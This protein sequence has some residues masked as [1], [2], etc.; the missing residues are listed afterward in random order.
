MRESAGLGPTRA[1]LLEVTLEGNCRGYISRA[2]P[3]HAPA[4]VMDDGPRSQ[5]SM[6][7]LVAVA[8][9]SCSHTTSVHCISRGLGRPAHP[10]SHTNH[11]HKISSL[12]S[13]H[14][15]SALTQIPNYSVGGRTVSGPL[16][17]WKDRISNSR[18]SLTSAIALTMADFA[19]ACRSCAKWLSELKAP[20][21]N[22]CSRETGLG[23]E[24]PSSHH[25]VC[26]A[27]SPDGVF[28][29]KSCYYCC[30][31]V[32]RL[33][34]FFARP[35]GRIPALFI[36]HSFFFFF[37]FFFFF[38][39][40]LLLLLLRT[41][42][43][44]LPFLLVWF[45]KTHDMLSMASGLL[46]SATPD[47][48]LDLSGT[49][50][51]WN[52]LRGSICCPRKSCC[53]PLSAV[54]I[55][56]GRFALRSWCDG[57][58]PVCSHCGSDCS[59]CTFEVVRFAPTEPFLL[60]LMFVFVRLIESQFSHGTH[61]GDGNI[62]RL[63]PRC[64]QQTDLVPPIAPCRIASARCQLVV[65]IA[66]GGRSSR[67]FQAGSGSGRVAGVAGT[68]GHEATR[69]RATATRLV[70]DPTTR[71][72]R[73]TASRSRGVTCRCAPAVVR[74]FVLRYACFCPF[75]RS[76]AWSFSCPHFPLS[77]TAVPVQTNSANCAT[78][79][80]SLLACSTNIE[81]SRSL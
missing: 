62:R 9:R 50:R 32:V 76:R 61:R 44:L 23:V 64:R 29:A 12:H 77:G 5:S 40:L 31:R 3:T 45:R 38:L 79:T 74:G 30:V 35:E 43:T 24:R 51:E 81:T 18:I 34:R 36:L 71:G 6:A 22:K 54:S 58:H 75:F 70:C 49:Y 53:S 65:V 2:G 33:F 47:S 72:L 48:S 28:L 66:V 20:K 69:M 17:F 39:L 26:S 13:S 25:L 41:A 80:L 27:C 55:P 37:F 14:P 10:R 42:V 21:C 52:E 56:A 59:W 63:V 57:G 4:D 16:E 19:S 15:R 8:V 7:R 46:G 73:A 68:A 78:K 11:T 60:A 67:G 1:R